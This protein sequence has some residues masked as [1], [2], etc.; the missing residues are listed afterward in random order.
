LGRFSA[1]IPLCSCFCALSLVVIR[2]EAQAPPGG[3]KLV[4]IS[5]SSARQ[6]V[7]YKVEPEYPAT[8]RQFHIAGEVIAQLTVGPDGKVETIDEAK[9]NLI[10]QASVKTV[11]RKWIFGPYVPEGKPTR[12]KTSLTFSFR[13]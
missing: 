13:L 3:D 2:V 9:G 11:L 5:E 4:F 1:F 12:F 10:L 6:L 8:A 7:K